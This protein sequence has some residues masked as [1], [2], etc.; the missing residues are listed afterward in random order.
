MWFTIVSLGLNFLLLLITLYVIFKPKP[1]NVDLENQFNDKKRTLEK[2]YQDE[3]NKLQRELAKKTREVTE[4]IFEL[5]RK[6]E[7][8]IQNE[9]EKTKQYKY[10]EIESELVYRIKAL[11]EKQKQFEDQLIRDFEIFEENYEIE[12][13]AIEQKLESLK[14]YE[15]SAV[16]ARVRMYEEANKEK[17]YMIQIEDSDAE[18]IDELMDIIPRLKNSMPLRKAIFDI[19]YRQPV[20]DL[21]YRVV[22]KESRPSGVY[23]ITYVETG[24]CYI[25]QSVDVGNRWLQHIKRGFALDDAGTAKLYSAMLKYGLH[26]FKFEVVEFCEEYMLNEKEKYWADYFKA[27]EFGFSIKN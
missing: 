3:D 27:K 19:Y 23:K 26:K 16:A 2:Q 6:L 17:F 5:R 11:K 20:R 14:S 10:Q 13:I 15:A 8:D 22:G 24:E 4:E 12:K 18:E 21:V 7:Q 9:L 1:N 25:G